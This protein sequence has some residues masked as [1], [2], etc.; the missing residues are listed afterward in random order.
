MPTKKTWR[1]RLF[2]TRDIWGSSWN[3]YA[4]SALGIGLAIA[5]DAFYRS[6]EGKIVHG[7]D[8]LLMLRYGKVLAFAAKASLVAAVL[9]AFREQLW[10]TVRSRFLSI[11]TLD[12][13]FAA[14]YTPLSL[15]NWDFCSKGKVVVVLALYSWLSPLIVIL[16]TNTLLVESALEVQRT[17]CPNVRSLNFSHEE[18]DNHITGTKINGLYQMSLSIWNMS[19]SY[20]KRHLPDYFEYWIGASRQ[21]EEV[22]LTATYSKRP[23]SN[24]DDTFKTCEKGWN[25]T[26]EIEFEGPAYRCQEISRGVEATDHVLQQESGNV[27]SPIP[28]ENLMPTG[29]FT[30]IAQAG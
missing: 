20:D 30:Y 12:D 23:L 16:T 29:N 2:P 15:L 25:C 24:F 22:F 9:S 11:A 21:A 26:V 3:M 18:T 10:A 28:Y 19:V 6:L 14:P 8:Q 4:F 5:H 13:I 7:D 17:V 1:A 27:E